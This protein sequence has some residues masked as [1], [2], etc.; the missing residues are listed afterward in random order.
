MKIALCFIA[1]L[2]VS[3]WLGDAKAGTSV[4]GCAGAIQSNCAG[5]VQATCSGAAVF[6]IRRTP[7]RDAFSSMRTNRLNRIN[8]RGVSLSCSGS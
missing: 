4:A 6:K 7:V 5:A 2:A 3:A 8:A 1:L